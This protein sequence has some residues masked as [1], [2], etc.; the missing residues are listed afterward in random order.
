MDD[1]SDLLKRYPQDTREVVE[2]LWRVLPADLRRDAMQ[3]SKILE[4]LAS[5]GA[6]AALLPAFYRMMEPLVGGESRAVVPLRRQLGWQVVRRATITSVLVALSPLPLPDLLPLPLIQ[7]SMVLSL[8]RIHAQ[9]MTLQRSAE[10]CTTFGVGAAARG[11]FEM[12]VKLGGPP[13]WILAAGIAGSTTLSIGFA[14]MRWFETQHAPSRE[15]MRRWRREL[16]QK[17]MDWLQSRF[18]KKPPE[19]QT[20]E[21]AINQALDGM[22]EPGSL[23]QQARPPR[24]GGAGGQCWGL[25]EGEPFI[26]GVAIGELFLPGVTVCKPVEV[27]VPGMFP[28]F[29]L[30]KNAPS[31][32]DSHAETNVWRC[33]FGILRDA[34]ACSGQTASL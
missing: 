16:E 23:P 8:A 9:K 3:I 22:I 26:P 6:P 18:G 30:R 14:T 17:L 21:Q 34:K 24:G 1:L 11:M 33:S 7:T 29:C 32:C 2:S 10:V 15:E 13:A 12:L 25:P 20:L 28:A 19:R 31:W 4:G 5:Q 27:E